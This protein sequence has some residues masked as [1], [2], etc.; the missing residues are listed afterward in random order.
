VNGACGATCPAGLALCNGACVSTSDP[1]LN[2]CLVNETFAV[3]VSTS[4]G[5][6]S[7]DGSRARPL[8]SI[9]AAITAAHSAH[10]S[11][12]ACAETYNESLT[13]ADGVAM[14]GGFS[15]AGGVWSGTSARALVNATNTRTGV[16]AS[17]IHMTTRVD[18]FQFV[19]PDAT[20]DVSSIGMTA[21]DAGGLWLTNCRVHAGNA[22]NG[23]DGIAGPSM[24]QA[25]AVNG[26]AGTAGTSLCEYPSG[27]VAPASMNG[28]A[29]GAG[30]AG[31]VLVRDCS[32]GGTTCT[33]KLCQQTTCTL[34]DY[35][36]SNG[37]AGAGPAGGAGGIYGGTAAFAGG[38]GTS[39]MDGI[40]GWTIGS[41]SHASG[42]VPSNGGTAG[43]A[44]LPGSGG[45]GA[46]GLDATMVGHPGASGT[47][48]GAGGCP[49]LPASPAAGGGAS[50]GILAWGSAMRIERSQIESSHGGNGGRGA[51]GSLGT[52]GGTGGASGGAGGRGGNA[53]SGA[54]GPSLGIASTGAAPV[55]VSCTTS[56]GAGGS[57]QPV[58]TSN[59]TT[60]AAS[61]NG[62]FANQYAF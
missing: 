24:I 8:A 6:A 36:P 40:S 46:A 19:T 62:A 55:L 56:I 30:G 27:S 15:C 51:F 54:G 59:G 14:Y 53:G 41:F 29:G 3:F 33:T 39:G 48:G 17:A 4:V 23:A 22:M 61:A 38:P 49:G 9:Q 18:S 11:V 42:Y 47:G 28:A 52:T 31:G 5:S 21:I 60:I 58:M 13:L 45:G 43:T 50:I 1:T 10:K 35:P 34:T 12:I 26:V 20:T 32:G 44:G 25:G 2:A 16:S 7:G 57:G 37:V